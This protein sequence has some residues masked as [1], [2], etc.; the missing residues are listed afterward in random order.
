LELLLTYAAIAETQHSIGNKQVAVRM[1][2]K[3]ENSYAALLPRL[4]EAKEL[5]ELT[6]ELEAHY[7]SKLKQVRERLDGLNLLG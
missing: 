5:K 4:S 3:A 7:Q 2:T 6:V 1:L